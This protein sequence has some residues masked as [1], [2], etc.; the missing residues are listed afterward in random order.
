QHGNDWS[1]DT[2]FLRRTDMRHIWRGHCRRFPGVLAGTRRKVTENAGRMI[3]SYC[4]RSRSMPSLVKSPQDRPS[5]LQPDSA[6]L[7]SVAKMFKSLS[8][9]LLSLV[10]VA[11]AHAIDISVRVVD[12]K[13]IAVDEFESMWHTADSGYSNWT[14]QRNGLWKERVVGPPSD[15]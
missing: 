8:A 4:P 15:V 6:T 14:R 10:F 7:K 2:Q 5:G 1:T 11:A 9:V 3:G 12:E 13:G